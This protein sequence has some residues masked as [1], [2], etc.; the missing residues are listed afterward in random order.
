M[1]QGSD[2]SDDDSYLLLNDHRAHVVDED[3]EDELPWLV[4]LAQ[5]KPDIALH[6]LTFLRPPGEHT[7]KLCDVIAFG[8][9]SK[10]TSSLLC[11]VPP[12]QTMMVTR[13]DSVSNHLIFHVVGKVSG[14]STGRTSNRRDAAILQH[15]GQ[16]RWKTRL[17]ITTTPPKRTKKK[18]NQACEDKT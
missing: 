8:M 16:D 2:T 13:F 10:V 4:N 6:I 17:P 15:V 7:T 1:F 5:G 12:V 9:V 11:K 14:P 18:D 3:A